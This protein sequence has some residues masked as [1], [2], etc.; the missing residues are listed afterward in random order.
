MHDGSRCAWSLILLEIVSRVISFPVSETVTVRLQ[1]IIAQVMRNTTNVLAIHSI[2]IQKIYHCYSQTMVCVHP[3]KACN[4]G[5]IL[6][7][8]TDG[9]IVIALVTGLV[10]CIGFLNKRWTVSHYVVYRCTPMAYFSRSWWFFPTHYIPVSY[11]PSYSHQFP[12]LCIS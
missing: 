6:R 4:L 7:I 1:T 5:H 11:I 3:S 8:F 9:H 2:C 10:V 12:P